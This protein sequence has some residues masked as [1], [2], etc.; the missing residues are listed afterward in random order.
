VTAGGY[1]TKVTMIIKDT[2]KNS[3]KVVFV[4]FVALVAFVTGAC[5]VGRVSG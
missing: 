5:A 1:F 2:K 4:I 3:K